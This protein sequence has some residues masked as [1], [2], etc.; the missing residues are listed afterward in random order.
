MALLR[1]I[2]GI[3][4]YEGQTVGVVP[5][6]T[7]QPP[8]LFNSILKLVNADGSAA[9]GAAAAASDPIVMAVKAGI[10]LMPPGDLKRWLS[11]NPVK[12]WTMVIQ[13]F[14]GRK[15]TT[16]EYRLGERFIDQV[17]HTNGPDTVKSYKDVPDNVVPQAQL[18]FTIL[19]GVRITTDEDLWALSSGSSA[20]YARPDKM[21]IP[22]QAVERAVYLA[23]RYYPSSS[24]NIA[25]WNLDYF[26]EYPLAAPIPDPVTFGKLYSGPLPGGGTATNGVINVNAE[27]PLSSLQQSPTVPGS[28]SN[29]TGLVVVGVG[30]LAV[31][32]YYAH[33]NKMI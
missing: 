5:A 16:G 20:Y 24:F 29:N 2:A 33:K 14:T 27:T 21:D 4:L 8:A 3:E 7:Q 26:S 17:L 31:G 10:N 9:S 15:Y 6:T 1:N 23:Q 12:F 11:A 22:P 13:L 25:E 32:A 18:L 19:F 28:G 30:L